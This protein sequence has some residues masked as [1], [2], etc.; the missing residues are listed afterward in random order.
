MRVNNMSADH[1]VAI[2]KMLYPTRGGIL[3][4]TYDKDKPGKH[5]LNFRSLG[6]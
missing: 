2:D 5:G 4:K 1:N 3:F 6:S